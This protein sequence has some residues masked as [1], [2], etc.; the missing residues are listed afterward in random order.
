MSQPVKL[1]HKVSHFVT[2]C[3]TRL[4][5]ASDSDLHLE[6]RPFY[7][8]QA[9]FRAW[10]DKCCDRFAHDILTNATR[11]ETNFEKTASTVR[12]VDDAGTVRRISGHQD[13]HA[14]RDEVSRPYPL[15]QGRAPI[16]LRL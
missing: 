15:S 16:A 5:A 13:K 1:R 11:T 6:L 2:N 7:V 14:L 12:V 9:E 4:S 10:Y 8:G 3:D